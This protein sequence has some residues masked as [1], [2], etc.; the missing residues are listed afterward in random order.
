MEAAAGPPVRSPRTFFLLVFALAIPFL[1]IG[2]LTGIQLLPGLP[3]AALMAV[4]P[5]TAALILTHRD[6]GPAGAKAL[7]KRAFDHHRIRKRVWYAPILLLMPGVM[8]LSFG[9]MRWSGTP[10]PAPQIAL[11]P[12]LIL[13]FAFFTSASAEEL[14]WS[15]YVIDPMQNRWGALGAS[16]LVGLGWAVFHYVALLQAHRSLAWIAWWSLWTVALR[17]IIV[18]LY[19]N[20]GKSVFAAALFHAT[21]NVTWQL[22][23]IQG[24]FFDPRVTGAITAFVA[25]AVIVVW[26]HGR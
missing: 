2:A 21:I 7:L 9:V 24:S 1:L 11:V 3:V 19:D 16:I 17:V 20:T 4:C 14:G 10:V 22:F 6:D 12:A 25:V 5:A 8:V 18:W 23:P 15:G 26:G 13:C